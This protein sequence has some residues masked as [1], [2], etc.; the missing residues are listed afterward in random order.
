MEK[1]ETNRTK[2]REL[3]ISDYKELYEYYKLDYIGSIVGFKP[4]ESSEYTK[5]YIE[6]EIKK[7]EL[8][9]IVS[10]NTNKVIGTIG[11][12]KN[13]EFDGLDIRMLVIILNPKFWGMGFAYEVTKELIRYAFEEK[14][15]HKLVIGYYSINKQS[16]SVVKK[17]GFVY[18]GRKREVYVYKNK[19]VDAIE[20][21]LLRSEYEHY[22]K[23]I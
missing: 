10:K 11:L 1:L 6:F 7:E 2:L 13:N 8:F 3:S 18:E 23:D 19:L 12:R 21:S 20:Y 4:H 5:K 16:E 14:K 17:L 15:I 9:A 22:N